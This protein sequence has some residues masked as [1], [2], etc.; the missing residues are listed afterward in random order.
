[1]YCGILILPSVLFLENVRIVSSDSKIA[2]IILGSKSFIFL[3][4]V[5]KTVQLIFYVFPLYSRL[6][7]IHFAINDNN[8]TYILTLL[9]DLQ[10]SFL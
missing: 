5:K 7:K 10:N 9:C 6:H 3:A 4:C 2:H 8:V 1:M